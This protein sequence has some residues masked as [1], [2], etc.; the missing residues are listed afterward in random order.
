MKKKRIFS[1][2]VSCAFFCISLFPMPLKAEDDEKAYENLTYTETFKGLSVTGCAEG[3]ETLVIPE[4]IDGKPVT[5]IKSSAFVNRPELK[6]VTLPESL[7]ELGDRAFTNCTALESVNLP[8]SLTAVKHNTFNGCSSLKS[9][10]IP[11]SVRTIGTG[12]FRNC[13]K[14]EEI[15]FP[16]QLD[17]IN[18]SAFTD[19]AWLAHQ[20]DG[21]V[22]ISNVLYCYNGVMP[23]NTELT[24]DESITVI[25]DGALSEQSN[26]SAVTFHDHIESIGWSAFRT[27]GIVSL[28]I[29]PVT[30]L[31]LDTFSDCFKLKRVTIPGTVKVIDTSVFAGCTHLESVTL[32][33]GLQAIGTQAFLDCHALKSITIPSSVKQIYSCAV[34]YRTPEKIEGDVIQLL[35]ESEDFTIYGYPYTAAETYASEN[36]FHFSEPANAPALVLGDVNCDGSFRVSDVVLFQK[37]LINASDVALKKPETADWNADGKLNATDL[38]MMKQALMGRIAKNLEINIKWDKSKKQEDEICR[39]L[40]DSIKQKLPS[41]DDSKFTFEWVESVYENRKTIS[42]IGDT[43]C[44]RLCYQGIPLDYEKY[45]VKVHLCDNGRYELEASFLT[46]DFIEKL[47]AIDTAKVI[48]KKKAIETAKEYASE[49]KLATK[50]GK[51]QP[52]ERFGENT[53]LVYFSVENARLAYQVSDP[54][55]NFYSVSNTFFT[56]RANVFVDAKTGEV[57]ENRYDE[58]ISIA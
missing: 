7:N 21:F 32:H 34:G 16:K 38:S 5:S 46:D 44:F 24:L 3:T 47:A 26:L 50:T 33:D 29:P 42:P 49:M 58:L 57:L 25:A 51:Y 13:T 41:F 37:W 12:A 9:I 56:V 45:A 43:I 39:Y 27:T 4:T 17:M 28:D 8:D 15:T 11:D 48:S 18:K 2:A 35:K 31:K 36:G 22:F 1:A 40:Q 6:S 30:E 52:S 14:L 54:L 10:V 53:D 55:S 19:T 23:Q 20:P